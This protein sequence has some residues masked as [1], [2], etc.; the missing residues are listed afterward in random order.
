MYEPNSTCVSHIVQE[1]NQLVADYEKKLHVLSVKIASVEDE[2][3]KTMCTFE[4]AKEAEVQQQNRLRGEA[5][6]ALRILTQNNAL[7]LTKLQNEV[8]SLKTERV[9]VLL[10]STLRLTL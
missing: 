1:K 6:E 4:E 8:E 7:E 5:Q 2:V 10:D 9:C 3:F